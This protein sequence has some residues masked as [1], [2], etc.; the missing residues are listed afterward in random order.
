MQWCHEVIFNTVEIHSPTHMLLMQLS[1]DVFI[2]DLD[3][4]DNVLNQMDLSSSEEFDIIPSS[5]NVLKTWSI[6]VSQMS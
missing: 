4:G 6:E 2:D 1:N 5:Q 3:S